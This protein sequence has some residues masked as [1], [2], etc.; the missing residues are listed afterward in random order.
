MF[1][2]VKGEKTDSKEV[3]GGRCIIRNYGK[4]CLS[5]KER[6]KVSKDYVKRI[7]N[8][9]N[10]WYHNVEVDTVEGAVDSVSREE[11]LQVL[12]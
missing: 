12:N 1:I 8:E 10:D 2:L 4:L 9:E 7:N 5:E 3:E 6:G 11:D